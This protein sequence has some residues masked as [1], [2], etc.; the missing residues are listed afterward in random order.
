MAKKDKNSKDNR[1]ALD[2]P[3]TADIGWI[4]QQ[5]HPALGLT[6]QRLAQLLIAAESG[7]L[8]AQADLG[9]DMEERDGHI[10]SE[11]DKR[12]QAV[13]SLDWQITPLKT[14]QNKKENSG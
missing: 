6:P 2:A 10:Y 4:N 11:L 1:A 14:P 12:K 8:T 5:E 9:A 13:K 3:Q 7:D